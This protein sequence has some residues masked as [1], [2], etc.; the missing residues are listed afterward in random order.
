MAETSQ[1]DFLNMEA[2]RL[3]EQRA[4]MQRLLKQSICPFCPE[5]IERAE[6]KP[7]LLRV[8]YWHVRENRWPYKNTRVH[9]LFIYNTHA[10]RLG[11]VPAEAGKELWALGR[12][13]EKE[14]GADGGGLLLRFGDPKIS[15]AT[16]KHLH[17]H[18]IVPLIGDRSQPDYQPV[19]FRVG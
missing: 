13:A 3:E 12:W 14:Y 9:L 15:C 10:E 7:I 6:M 2:A 17:A 1:N 16:V 18:F 11:G 19:R 4:V 8:G 5:Y